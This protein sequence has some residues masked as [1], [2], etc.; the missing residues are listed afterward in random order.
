MGINP[1]D[2]LEH[3][4]RPACNILDMQSDA[5]DML[6]LGT[7]AA[8]S[9]CGRYLK[10]IGGGPA[11]GIFQMEPDTY[12]DIWRNYISFRPE[13]KQKLS[14]YWPVEPAPEKMKTELIFAAVMCRIHYRRV[15]HPLPDSL[16]LRGLARYWKKHYNSD[17]G[18]GEIEHFEGALFKTGEM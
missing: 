1:K 17:L 18:A 9:A 4:I 6:L 15:P 13:I 11:L 3:V 16:D 12:K 14:L 5:A 8:E 7:C 10:Q 2:L